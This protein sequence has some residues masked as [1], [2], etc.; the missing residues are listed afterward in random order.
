[1]TPASGPLA[2]DVTTTGD[3]ATIAL[4]GEIDLATA[5]QFRACLA[6]CLAEGCTDITL[7]MS[8][9]NY[10][11]S[12]GLTAMAVT[13]KQLENRQGRLA[14]HQPSPMAQRVLD[15]TGLSSIIEITSPGADGADGH[16]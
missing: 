8:A 11:D 2:I 13:R 1:M 15:L 5:P 12:A 10:I 6:Q 9:L 16:R 14:V 7:D 3:H 4:S